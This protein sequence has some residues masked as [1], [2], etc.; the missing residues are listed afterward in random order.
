MPRI[1]GNKGTGYKVKK[2][3]AAGC[4]VGGTGY[5]ST[6]VQKKTGTWYRQGYKGTG[7]Q[8][9]RYADVQGYRISAK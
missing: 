6:V 4:R 5:K 7:V 8:G 1:L 3:R 2:Y 9:Y